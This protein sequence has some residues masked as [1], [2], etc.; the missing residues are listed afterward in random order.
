MIILFVSTFSRM[1][2]KAVVILSGRRESK[3]LRTDLTANVFPM[4][5]F[6]DFARNDIALERL[7]GEPLQAMA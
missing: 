4:R 6:L 3:D 1:T 2:P 5:R 7:C